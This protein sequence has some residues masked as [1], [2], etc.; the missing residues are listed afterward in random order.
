MPFKTQTANSPTVFLAG[1]AAI[2]LEIALARISVLYMGHGMLAA[3]STLSLYLLG[4]ALPSILLISSKRQFSHWLPFVLFTTA[5][6]CLVLCFVW[7]SQLQLSD[8][9]HLWALASG[10]LVMAGFLAG[11][12]LPISLKQSS[13]N[14]KF[15]AMFNC[16]GALGGLLTG[17][18]LLP[19]FGLFNL[20][21]STALLFAFSAFL[22]FYKYPFDGRAN[23]QPETKTN[24]QATKTNTGNEILSSQ[25]RLLYLATAIFSC[26]TIFVETCLIRYF[27]QLCGSSVTALSLIAS[28]FIGA[29]AVGNLLAYKLNNISRVFLPAEKILTYTCLLSGLGLIF[30]ACVIYKFPFLYWTFFQTSMLIPAA[31]LSLPF[32]TG[33]GVLWPMLC[34]YLENSNPNNSQREFR[35]LYLVSALAAALAPWFLV[36]AFNFDIVWGSGTL[37]AGLR[38]SII[39]SCLLTGLFNFIFTKHWRHKSNIAAV[40][41]IL[42]TCFSPPLDKSVLATGLR[43]LAEENVNPETAKE[44]LLAEKKYQD[45]LYFKD[46]LVATIALFKIEH[47][48]LAILREDGRTEAAVA[49]DKTLPSAGAQSTQALLAL[50]PYQ[51]LPPNSKK[52]ALVIGLGLGTTSNTAALLPDMTS[53]LTCELEP[54]VLKAKTLLEK[55]NNTPAQVAEKVLLEDAREFLR[56]GSSEQNSPSDESFSLIISQPSKPNVSGSTDLFS[57][58]FLLLAQR[59][60][61]D[62]GVFSQWLELRGLSQ[63]ALE[64]YLATFQSVFPRCFI[65]QATGAK[66]IIIIGLKNKV[67]L[68]N[69][70]EDDFKPETI[71]QFFCGR[72]RPLFAQAR[73]GK[74][75]EYLSFLRLPQSDKLANA[76]DL[77]T[78][79]TDDNMLLA[80]SQQKVLVPTIS[81]VTRPMFSET[82]QVELA[83]N[84][85]DPLDIDKLLQAAENDVQAAR[86]L[87]LIYPNNAE[88]QLCLARQTLRNFKFHQSR[89]YLEEA[90]SAIN[91]ALNLQP[92]SRQ[93]LALQALCQFA[94]DWKNEDNLNK[95]DKSSVLIKKLVQNIGRGG[96][97]IEVEKLLSRMDFQSP[98]QASQAGRQLK[99]SESKAT[100][101]GNQDLN[102]LIISFKRALDS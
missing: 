22:T 10:L 3:A 6:F 19:Q 4:M 5:L 94:L 89:A 76:H 60:L 69:R 48:N 39:T 75:R 23:S 59:R 13:T 20:L 1:C 64:A 36:A 24:P 7:R 78:F 37:E 29:M 98:D 51:F 14:Q 35:L 70:E 85:A 80:K 27:S 11:T 72:M 8:S 12:V 33:Q 84:F 18:Y 82:K 65:F 15:Y 102:V 38:L 21:A 74:L 97:L 44:Q 81:Q 58:E 43:F 79:A 91:C 54:A 67:G 45:L 55:I 32:A 93:A 56:R 77:K 47:I 90:N 30:C 57:R 95:N 52:N 68:K 50:L 49:I 83:T 100:K 62:D 25:R 53:V 63:S 61:N 66:E 40:S 34:N 16:G 26:Q 92:E 87:T 31:C 101:L 88:G 99:K 17:L 46:G 9:N 73:L 42:L 2:M 71:A 96:I 41:L 86:R 28:L